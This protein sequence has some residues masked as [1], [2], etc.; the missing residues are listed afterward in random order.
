MGSK[1]WSQDKKI[2]KRKGDD[3][4]RRTNPALLYEL[5]EARRCF[6]DAENRRSPSQA[7]PD[8]PFYRICQSVRAKAWRGARVRKGHPFL[9]RK[10]GRARFPCDP[11]ERVYYQPAC[12]S[13]FVRMPCNITSICTDRVRER[14]SGR[15]SI[16][17]IE[18]G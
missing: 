12:V 8:G 17:C 18:L 5:N 4:L 11:L 10:R 14:Y 6:G 16:L 13:T 3:P 7:Y 15:E 2:A 9:A 1:N